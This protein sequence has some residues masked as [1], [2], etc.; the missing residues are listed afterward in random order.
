M[1]KKYDEWLGDWLG[2]ERGIH[3]KIN[4]WLFYLISGKKYFPKRSANNVYIIK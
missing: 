1:V 3:A 4:G 2:R